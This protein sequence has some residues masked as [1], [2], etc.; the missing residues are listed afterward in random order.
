MNI[1][2]ADIGT[3][4]GLSILSTLIWIYANQ[5]KG[6]GASEYGPHIFPQFLAVCMFICALMLI[7]L[8]VKNKS[9]VPADTINIRGMFRA[10]IAILICIAYIIIMQLIGYLAATVIFLFVMM[11]FVQQKGL[12]TRAVVS[13]TV[14]LIIFLL[15]R[16]F[17]KIP[18]PEAD[19]TFRY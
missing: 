3:G 17:L 12:I 15:F 18:L 14:A 7:G 11:T 19:F 5:Y 16:N 9:V 8:A 1:K 4:I 2:K 13:V 6:R 10:G